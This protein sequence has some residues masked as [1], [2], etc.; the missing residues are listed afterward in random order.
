MGPT[1]LLLAIPRRTTILVELNR[2][3][4]FHAYTLLLWMPILA[5]YHPSGMI[6]PCSKRTYYRD[7]KCD[8]ENTSR[9]FFLWFVLSCKVDDILPC[10]NKTC[11]L[12]RS[13]SK[14]L[15]FRKMCKYLIWFKSQ[16]IWP[17]IAMFEQIMRTGAHCFQ[18]ILFITSRK[19]CRKIFFVVYVTSVFKF[20]A[21]W[22]PP[23]RF[24][25]LQK[26]PL[27]TIWR[28]NTRACFKSL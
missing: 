2:W 9:N 27:F 18:A 20:L 15:L 26:C 21:D 13:S 8:I 7:V 14:I 22:L 3:V 17:I 12:A 28:K 16:Q 24:F 19:N 25:D 6:V 11:F 4:P 1:F 10:I 23:A 5:F